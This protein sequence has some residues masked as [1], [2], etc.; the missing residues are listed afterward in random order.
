M[1]GFQPP[2]DLII[3]PPGEVHVWKISAGADHQETA[4]PADLLSPDEKE[5]AGRFHFEK[6][7][8]VFIM[9]R[10][11]LRTLLGRYAGV[12]PGSIRFIYDGHGKPALPAAGNAES[13][14]FSVSHSGAEILLAFGRGFPVGIDVERIRDGLDVE[15]LARRYFSPVEAAQYLSLPEEERIEA[16]FSCWARKE[17]FLKARGEGLSFG[18]DRFEVTLRPGEPARLV[19]I[20]G[21]EAEAKEWSLHDIP[22][23]PGFKA[24]LAARTRQP[25]ISCYLWTPNPYR[26]PC[27]G[28]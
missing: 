11:V 10:G 16:F 20:V 21:D 12:E 7:R 19:K 17:A 25:R 18:L 5:R 4:R 14:A 9:G 26:G 8:R 2:P 24:A 15:D 27:S 23:G 22:V 1:L 3:L 28:G 13:P 6:D